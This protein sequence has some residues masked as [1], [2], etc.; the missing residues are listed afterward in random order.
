MYIFLSVFKPLHIFHSCFKKCSSVPQEH[1]REMEGLLDNI[2]QLDRELS[3]NKLI[4]DMF[5]PPEYQEVIEQAVQWNEDIGEFQLK[6]VA[7]T[8]NNMR[9]QLPAA[10]KEKK[11]EVSG[12]FNVKCF[13]NWCMW[14]QKAVIAKLQK[15]CFFIVKPVH[16]PVSSF[17]I[18]KWS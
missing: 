8:G 18:A 15:T 16:S 10:E 12:A 11:K 14:F 13:Q 3:L 9:K 1:Q 6:C 5:I 4:I 7:Y 2:R 17:A